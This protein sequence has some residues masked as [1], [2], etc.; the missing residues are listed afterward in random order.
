M[1]PLAN[2]RSFVVP[3]GVQ[4]MQHDDFA[5]RALS[6]SLY[7]KTALGLAGQDQYLPA[8]AVIRS[9]LEHHLT[10]R[11]LFLARLYLQFFEK[12]SQATYE[13]LL[14]DLKKQAPSTENIIDMSW[15][16]GHL[17]VTRRGLQVSGP[18]GE[19]GNE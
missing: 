1:G 11:L 6:L 5:E 13:G 16:S 4:H 7:L 15:E 3:R 17:K 9:A 10:D 12:V 18:G 19:V 8:F 2:F 14:A